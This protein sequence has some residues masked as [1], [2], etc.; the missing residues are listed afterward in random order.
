[1]SAV[2]SPAASGSTPPP[3]GPPEHKR[4][5]TLISHSMLFYWW[6]IWILGFVMALVTY[7]E[8][9]RLA[10]VPSETT[11]AKLDGDDKSTFYKFG[12]VKGTETK[13]LLK[14]V[15]HSSTPGESLRAFPTRVS[16]K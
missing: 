12:I 1:M 13:S 7:M 6:P 3:G 11:V 8:D 2:P 14:A 16:A 15:E 5:I 9:H 10:I 4:E